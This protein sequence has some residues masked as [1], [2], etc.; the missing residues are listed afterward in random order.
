PTDRIPWELRPL[1]VQF[2]QL[3]GRVEDTIRRE[4]RFSMDIAHELRTPASELHLLM[5]LGTLSNYPD[6]EAGSI[7]D[8]REIYRLGGEI[9]ERINTILEALI[10]IHRGESQAIAVAQEPVDLGIILKEA[11]AALDSAERERFPL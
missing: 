5:Q 7:E 9:T 1:I 10:A 11:V 8:P 2:N 6:V 3:I 4:R